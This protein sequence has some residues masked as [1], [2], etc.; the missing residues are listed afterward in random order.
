MGPIGCHETSVQNYHSAL[1]NT[2]YSRRAQISPCDL[3]VI[4]MNIAVFSETAMCICDSRQRHQLHQI[5]WYLTAKL[6]GVISLK[7]VFF[8]V[9]VM[10]TCFYVFFSEMKIKRGTYLREIIVVMAVTERT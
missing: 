7:A 3:F 5:R 1:R 10:R 8:I 2:S 6:Y 9:T 4:E